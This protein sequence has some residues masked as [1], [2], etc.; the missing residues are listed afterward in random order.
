MIIFIKNV[1][2]ISAIKLKKHIASIS[3][4]G[5][6]ISKFCYIKKSCLIILFKVDKSLK[7]YFYHIILPFG[8]D[9][10]LCVESNKKALVNA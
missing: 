8:Q 3:I 5:I 7:I 1:K 6:I 2:I 4:F 10:H 9:A